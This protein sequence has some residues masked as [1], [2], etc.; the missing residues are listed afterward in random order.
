MLDRNSLRSQ[1][2]SLIDWLGE[3]RFWQ[4]VSQPLQG[5]AVALGNR[6]W[7]DS[8]DLGDLL[9]GLLFDAPKDDD[10]ASCQHH[11]PWHWLWY[12]DLHA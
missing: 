4:A 10:F 1:P 6:L 11:D 8:E 2:S 7:G 9:G 5:T 12:A 3:D